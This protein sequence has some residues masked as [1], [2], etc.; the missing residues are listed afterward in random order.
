MVTSWKKRL[1]LTAIGSTADIVG[2][3]SAAWLPAEAASPTEQVSRQSLGAKIVVRLISNKTVIAKQ[4][5][6][7]VAKIDYRALRLP[8]SISIQVM[9]RTLLYVRMS[10]AAQN[11][12]NQIL[13]AN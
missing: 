8:R 2:K 6:N 10:T 4:V 5:N 9:S 13:F 7:Q 12:D 3:A 11:A 1:S